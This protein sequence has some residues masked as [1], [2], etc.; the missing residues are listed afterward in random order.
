MKVPLFKPY[1]GKE[2]LEGLKKIFDTGWIG[3]GPNTA[4][5]E[6]MFANYV[7]SRV[8]IG[9]NSATSALHLALEI[10][11]L[12]EG[13]VLVPTVTF[14]S[15][16]HVVEYNSQLRVKFVDVDYTLCMD[17]QDLQRKLSSK[18]K[19]IIPV[20]LG[21]QACKM[22]EILKIVKSY[23]PDIKVIED[24]ANAAGG[25]YKG[26]KLGTWGD[27]GC[28]SFEA[29]KNMTTGDGG[30]LTTDIGSMRDRLKRLRWV[31]M[32]K[33]TWKR[34]STD[35]SYSWYYEIK[36]LGYKYNMNDIA[37]TIG[38]EQL[39]KLEKVNKRKSEIMKRYNAGLK[40]LGWLKIPE[41]YDLEEGSYWLYIVKVKERDKFF[42]Y[43]GQNGITA[44]VHF[45]PI[46]LHPYYKKKYQVTLPES[47]RIWPEIISLPLFY[48]LSDEM[49]DYVIRKIKNFK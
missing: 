21:G 39:K 44:G 2:E 4:K 29:K 1:I 22:D 11:D 12:K 46:H 32:D 30:M 45:M 42:D 31:G 48:E 27:I 20:H 3:L 15:T 5:F 26:K 37:A 25:N 43:L 36:E 40:D 13:E 14:V 38:I 8:A 47:E 17:L 35:D 19:A 34:F 23:N 6:T 24:C 16:A 49:V 7:G 10:F 33:D 9:T 18:T 28:F 41:Y